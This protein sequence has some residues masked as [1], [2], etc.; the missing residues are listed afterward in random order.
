MIFKW[1]KYRKAALLCKKQRGN[2][3][4]CRISEIFGSFNFCNFLSESYLLRR[5]KRIEVENEPIV[6]AGLLVL[7]DP[8]FGLCFGTSTSTYPINP[9][10]HRNEVH[11]F[12]ESCR[13][14]FIPFGIQGD[15]V[16]TTY[17]VHTFTNGSLMALCDGIC[18]EAPGIALVS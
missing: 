9:Q 1:R 17:R 16:N 6:T 11:S 4:L 13:Q 10:T 14:E 8:S 12:S 3:V 15:P 18:N 2:L 7:Q 5:L